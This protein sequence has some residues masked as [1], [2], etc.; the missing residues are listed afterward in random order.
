MLSRFAQQLRQLGD[1][2]SNPSRLILAE[3]LGCGSSARLIFVI[4]IGELLAVVVTHDKAGVQFLDRPRRR[5][6]ARC[7]TL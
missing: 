1:I 5:E 2:H 3:Q 4:D 7:I 6:A